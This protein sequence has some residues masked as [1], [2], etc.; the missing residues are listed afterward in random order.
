V[1]HL[2][3]AGFL[4]EQVNLAESEL[5][6]MFLFPDAEPVEAWMGESQADVAVPA[7]AFQK[8]FKKH[9]P[10]VIVSKASFVQPAMT[11]LGIKAPRDVAFV[12]V[13]LD[14]TSGATAG[15]RQNHATVGGLA[16]EI[17]AGQL[18]HN[19]YGVPEI[20]TTTYVEGTWFDGKSCPSRK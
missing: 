17:L 20:P 4:C 11:E 7:A 1:D 13:F 16:V 14:D 18:Q 2:W 10:E 9:K 6:P 12:D 5:V 3:T 8:W 19:K 15:V